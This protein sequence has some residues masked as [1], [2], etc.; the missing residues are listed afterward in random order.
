M[1]DGWVAQALGTIPPP[2]MLSESLRSST[3]HMHFPSG[4]LLDVCFDTLTKAMPV[5]E[6][7][8]QLH[9]TEDGYLIGVA[10]N[11]VVVALKADASEEDQL[12]AFVH[13]HIVHKCLTLEKSVSD[14]HSCMNQLVAKG[15]PLQLLDDRNEHRLTSLRLPMSHGP[16]D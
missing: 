5:E 15:F 14:L 7:V 3:S 8:R 6:L 4:V 11:Q 12:R 2:D 1:S 13:A 10:K 16:L 9:S